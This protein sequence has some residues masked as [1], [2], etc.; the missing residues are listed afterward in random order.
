MD[1]IAVKLQ[2]GPHTMFQLDFV[3]NPAELLERQVLPYYT[4]E[5]NGLV[6]IDNRMAYIISFEQLPNIDVPLY[7]GRYYVGVDDLAFISA[8]F[9]ISEDRI[10]KVSEYMVRQKP[11]NIQIDI[12]KAHYLV[13]YQWIDDK[14]G[15][16]Y[17]RSEVSM[18]IKRKK[19]YFHSIYTTT[20]EMVVTDVDSL[21]ITK[22][23]FRESAGNN[24]ILSDQVTSFED[25]DFWGDY[26]IIH[27]EESIQT[28][29]KRMGRKLK[30]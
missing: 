29:V 15:L 18:V 8:E 7:K 27:P 10:D 5:I 21:H 1:T 16:S 3:K 14:W 12:K 22:Y 4:Y 23:K 2:G 25:P 30:R 19:K 9:W 24:D 28:A 17:V 6:H 11:P 13:N 26:N 20:A